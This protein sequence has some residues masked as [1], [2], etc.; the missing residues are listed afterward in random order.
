MN[1]YILSDFDCKMANG[2]FY[3]PASSKAECLNH[4]FCWSPDSIVTGLLTPV[5]T[6]TGSCL[7]GGVKQ[8]LFTWN[9]AKW[10]GGAFASTN[11]TVRRAV[12]SNKIQNA[13]NFPLLQ[14]VVS[15]PADISLVFSLKNQVKI[16]SE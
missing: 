2:K 12:Q 11:W 1:H 13:I 10:I 4:S 14:S 7:D 8:S 16:G 15:S 9:E 3:Y 6:I 5:D